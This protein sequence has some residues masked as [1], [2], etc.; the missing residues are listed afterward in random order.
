MKFNSRVAYIHISVAVGAPLKAK[1]LYITISIR[2]P[3]KAKYLLMVCFCSKL[4]ERI[5][6][7][8]PKIRKMYARNTS[9]R[10][11]KRGARDK[12]LTRLP[13]NTPLGGSARY[14]IF[15]KS[16]GWDTR[17]YRG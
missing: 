14:G 15:A 11:P 13:L 1:Y 4:S 3:L 16:A 7:L 17:T 10:S 6:H 2:G 9:R 8:S 12:C 5:I